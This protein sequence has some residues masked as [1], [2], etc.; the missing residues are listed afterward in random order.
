M[1]RHPNLP[2][3]A[4]NFFRATGAE[5]GK[6][7]AKTLSPEQRSQSARKAVKARWAKIKTKSSS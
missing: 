1:K 5:G 7:R 4:L 3:E 6:K 2:E